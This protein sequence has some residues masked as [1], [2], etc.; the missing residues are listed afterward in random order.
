MR[1]LTH[2]DVAKQSRSAMWPWASPYLIELVC[3]MMMWHAV[4]SSLTITIGQ[5][6][7]LGIMIESGS[8]IAAGTR[9]SWVDYCS[10]QTKPHQLPTFHIHLSILMDLHAISRSFNEFFLL[11]KFEK[12]NPNQRG[13]NL[14]WKVLTAQ[15]RRWLDKTDRAAGLQAHRPAASNTRRRDV[16]RPSAPFDSEKDDE[17]ISCRYSVTSD[18]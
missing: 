16:R 2:G 14:R 15:Y 4:M 18:L 17:R 13:K 1:V 7:R 9:S 12:I 10:R 8:S 3:L 6:S 5:E 11:Y